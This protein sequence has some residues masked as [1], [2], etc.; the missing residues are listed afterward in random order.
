M[1]S[2]TLIIILHTYRAT[3]A[4]TDYRHA[5]TVKVYAL[6][7][8]GALVIVNVTLCL[9]ALAFCAIFVED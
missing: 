5:N 8:A 2:Y 9:C 7:K 3:E 4:C 1:T 6:Q